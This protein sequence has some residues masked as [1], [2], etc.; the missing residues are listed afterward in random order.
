M[1]G[2][3][4]WIPTP[5]CLRRICLLCAPTLPPSLPTSSAREQTTLALL[6]RS[7]RGGPPAWSPVAGPCHRLLYAAR[8][9][10]GTVTLLAN[11][12]NKLKPNA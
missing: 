2:R 1:T 4:L 10:V 6:P 7:C 3:S 11:I 8:L 5:A 9:T 12:K